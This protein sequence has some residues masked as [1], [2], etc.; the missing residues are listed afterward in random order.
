VSDFIQENLFYKLLDIKFNSCYINKKLANKGMQQVKEL[1]DNDPFA[2]DGMNFT[3]FKAYCKTL[4][5]KGVTVEKTLALFTPSKYDGIYNYETSEE[6]LVQ[7]SN[8]STFECNRVKKSRQYY[9][10]VIG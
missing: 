5:I 1:F 2:I 10:Q 9:F 8:P 6:V 3:E 4:G 7:L